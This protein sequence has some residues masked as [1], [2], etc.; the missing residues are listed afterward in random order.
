MSVAASTVLSHNLRLFVRVNICIYSAKD[1]FKQLLA[2]LSH[3]QT[4]GMYQF[5][6]RIH[7]SF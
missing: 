1:M 3:L 4:L 6:C 2:G 5:D 7:L